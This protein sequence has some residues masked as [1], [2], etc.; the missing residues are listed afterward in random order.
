MM[1]NQSSWRTML[2]AVVVCGSSNNGNNGSDIRSWVAALCLSSSPVQQQKQSDLGVASCYIFFHRHPTSSLFV[3]IPERLLFLEHHSYYFLPTFV[4][5]LGSRILLHFRTS[6]Q[7]REQRLLTASTSVVV[8]FRSF[9]L[10]T[11]FIFAP[12]PMFLKIYYFDNFGQQQQY[13]RILT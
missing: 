4:V 9:F 12:S 2:S 3:W 7:A 6:E 5:T 13:Y 10:L 1:L 8:S 11:L